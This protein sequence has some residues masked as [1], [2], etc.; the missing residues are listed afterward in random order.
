MSDNETFFNQLEVA[1]IQRKELAERTTIAKLKELLSIF[2]T[3]FQNLYNILMRKALIQQDPY[4]DDDKITTIKI[5]S[6]DPIIESG[7]QEDMSHRIS[8]FHTQ[9]E[10][11]NTYF[12]LSLDTLSIKDLKKIIGL[13]KY[14]NW[15]NISPSSTNPPTRFIGEALQKIKLGSD[16]V[17]TQ[18]IVDSCGQ[19]E[20]NVRQIYALLED[21]IIIV[22]EIYKYEVRK[23]VL[24][25]IEK[26]LEVLAGNPD[27]AIKAIKSIFPKFISNKSFY[28][29]L[30]KEILEEDYS[31]KK[32]ALHKAILARLKVKEKKPQIEKKIK[33]FKPI[34]LQG[35]RLVASSGFHIKDTIVKLTENHSAYES[36]KK[37][38]IAKI[39]KWFRKL[40]KGKEPSLVYDIEYFDVN[41]SSTR[42]E[43]INFTEFIDDLNKKVRFYSAIMNR[44]S[45]TYSKLES[46]T[47]EK[48]YEYL[49][50]NLATL[51]IMHRQL[52][53]FNDFFKTEIPKERRYKV[54]TINLELN[55][56]KNSTVKANK[57]KHE[58]VSAKEEI[59]QLK[60]LGIKFEGAQ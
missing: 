47:E 1:I 10:F 34:L 16:K 50:R 12:Q 13:M 22:R 18:I 49:N 32:D 29:D 59:E 7:F 28:P 36:R 41:T 31:D 6:S 57:K 5:P 39:V 23:F 58:Y 55:A 24:P 25:N 54:R 11:L 20:K 42:T 46:A 30:I 33:D 2:Q 45:S 17:S 51:H 38:I 35:L 19:I 53:G 56:I 21:L 4:K 37:N 15:L 44:A 43:R 26:D 8:N 52:M 60:R 14:I 40:F 27:G 48:L 9:I 3:Y